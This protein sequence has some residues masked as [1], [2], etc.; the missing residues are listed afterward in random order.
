M[1][2]SKVGLVEFYGVQLL[3]YKANLIGA[4]ELVETAQ[5]YLSGMKSRR[6][7]QLLDS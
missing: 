7:K 6:L 3:N 1:E 5:V 4:P 2:N